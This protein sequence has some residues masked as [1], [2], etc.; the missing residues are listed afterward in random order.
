MSAATRSAAADGVT[1]STRAGD[2]PALRRP[3]DGRGHG[4]VHPGAVAAILLLVVNDHVLKGSYPG[5][6]TGKLSDFAGLAFFPLLLQA[7]LELA[8]ARVSRRVLGG[9]IVASGLL[10]VAVKT[11]PWANEAYI[12]A[13]GWLLA[14]WA[15]VRGE[16][17]PPVVRLEMDPTDLW[18]LLALA[19]AW[20][21]GRGRR[22]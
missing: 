19:L 17:W 3:N 1:L 12:R 4:L 13:A 6:V 7:L 15:W 2:S 22:D 11:L 5:V 10:M 14:P 16:P 9:C 21:W 8:G 20:H 18:A